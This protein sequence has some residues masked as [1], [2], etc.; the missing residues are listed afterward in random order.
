MT[1]ENRRIAPNKMVVKTGTRFGRWVVEREAEPSAT[2]LRRFTAQ[3][4]CGTT[5]IVLLSSLH[6]GVSRSCGCLQREATVATHTKHGQARKGHVAKL[7]RVWQEMVQRCTNPRNKRWEN[8][9]GRGIRVCDRWLN[10]YADFAADIG[11]RP[12][13]SHTIDRIDNDGHYEPSN[14]RWATFAEQNTNRRKFK[15][16]RKAIRQELTT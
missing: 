10:S 3:C 1:T 11:V 16:R 15:Q 8:Y 9:G 14:V 7:F 12:S 5:R 6:H 4:D 13:A 2:G